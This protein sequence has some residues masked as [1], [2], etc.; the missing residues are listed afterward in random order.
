M[1]I[2]LHFIADSSIVNFG[3]FH[4]V[5]RLL[6]KESE[7][8]LPAR[9]LLHLVYNPVK[10][11]TWFAYLWHWSFHNEGSCS[12][13]VYSKPGETFNE[14]FDFMEM[15]GD[16]LCGQ[17]PASS[18][19][20][21]QQMLTCSASICSECEARGMSFS[22]EIDWGW[23]CRKML[24]WNIF[25]YWF[26]KAED[27]WRGHKELENSELSVPASLDVMCSLWNCI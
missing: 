13:S 19:D 4:S 23:E 11:G 3:K 2:C 14:I 24:Q 25:M 27:S 10:K 8:I 7:K 16:N 20:C 9:C 18:Y 26:C 22:L 15:E 6:T 5:Y 17:E 21:C 12:P 1:L